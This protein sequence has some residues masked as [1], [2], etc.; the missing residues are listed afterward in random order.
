[1]CWTQQTS[2][3]AKNCYIRLHISII[4]VLG[5]LMSNT[6]HNKMAQPKKKNPNIKILCSLQHCTVQFNF[7][8]RDCQ[9]K[10]KKKKKKNQ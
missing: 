6:K 7:E 3:F 10:K 5:Y 1:M 9:K 4:L 8:R 2:E